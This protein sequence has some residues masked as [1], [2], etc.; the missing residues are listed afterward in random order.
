VRRIVV[1]RLRGGELEAPAAAA[2]AFHRR[3]PGYEATPLRDA[4]PLSDKLGLEHVWVKDEASRFGL[5]AFKYLGASWAVARVLGETQP[6]QLWAAAH[7]MGVRRLVA[8]TDG[9]HG[10]AVARIAREIGLGATIYVPTGMVAARRQAIADE[11]AAVIAVAEE[12]DSAVRMATDEAADPAVR[13]INDADQEGVSPVPGW[14]IE[15]YSTLFLEVQEQLP[16]GA[17]VDLVVLQIGVGAFAAAGVRWAAARGVRAV[18]AEPAGAAC[19]AASLAAGSPQTILTTGTVMAGLDCQS[20]SYAAWPAVAAGLLG[21]VLLDDSE[22]DEATRLLAEGGIESG[23]SGAA[24]VAALAA[25]T[26]DPKCAP[27]RDAAGWDAVRSVLVV[28]TEGAT[29]PDRY[30]LVVG[31]SA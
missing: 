31:R 8:A 23:E 4:A 10:R 3:L 28:N 5:P 30:R 26:A 24:G 27:L 2:L 9:N 22:A 25:L 11:G 18:G 15:G 7:R 13:V 6:G 1:N 12:Y 19:M 20:P 21:I 16:A 17:D 29:D 14:V